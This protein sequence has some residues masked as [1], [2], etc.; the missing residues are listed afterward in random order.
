VLV[1]HG[2]TCL[3]TAFHTYDSD[4]DINVDCRR[5]KAK[6]KVPLRNG[7]DRALQNLQASEADALQRIRDYILEHARGVILWVTLILKDL[8]QTAGGGMFTFTELESRL[9]SLPLELDDL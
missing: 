2:I 6:R 9:K 4:S 5:D 1:D 7:M 8:Q 3:Q